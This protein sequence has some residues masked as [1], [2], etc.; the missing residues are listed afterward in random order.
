MKSSVAKRTAANSVAEPPKH[1]KIA[2]NHEHPQEADQF[3]PQR[4]AAILC[5]L[6]DEID[7]AINELRAMDV[8]LGVQKS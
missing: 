4:L 7:E 3:G 2:P 1:M 5:L 6:T 8:D